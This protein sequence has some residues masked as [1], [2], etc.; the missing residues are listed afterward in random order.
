MHM[1]EHS[2]SSAGSKELSR[3][4][5][6]RFAQAYVDSPTHSKGAELAHLVA[7]AA[8][9]PDWRVLDVATGGGHTALAFAPQV[10]FVT[11][12]DLTPKMLAAAEAFILA[13]GASNVDFR[14]ADAENLPFADAC[15]DLVTCRIAPHHFPDCA[16]FVVEATRVLKPGGRLLVQDHVLPADREAASYVDDFERL[17]DPSHHQAFD[18]AGWRG[19]FEAAGLAVLHGEEIVKRHAFLPWATRQGCGPETLSELDRRLKEAPPAA[20]AWMQPKDLGGD[21]AS[22]VNHHLIILG[23]KPGTERG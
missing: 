7:L 10:A 22:F 19:M 2:G 20:A 1:K 11:A 17:R 23:Q 14:L 5:Y 13:A 9:Q 6:G 12:S 3:E 15:F 4:R 8:P 16:R 18:E 21:E